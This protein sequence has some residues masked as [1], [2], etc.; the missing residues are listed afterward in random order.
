[1]MQLKAKGRSQIHTWKHEEDEETGGFTITVGDD[2]QKVAE[3]KEEHDSDF[4][5]FDK[6]VR[7]T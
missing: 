2:N 3:Q 5:A 1:M 4:E 6:V 7:G